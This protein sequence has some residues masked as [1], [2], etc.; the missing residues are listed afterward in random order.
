M[1]VFSLLFLE[2]LSGKLL[3]LEAELAQ[4]RATEAELMRKLEATVAERESLL[5]SIQ[6]SQSAADAE[7]R[8][9]EL[10]EQQLSSQV[11]LWYL[12]F[13]D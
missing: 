7:A 8:Q 6:K 3:Q 13:R 2:L 5:A 9:R 10:V 1:L 12:C 11:I 4:Q